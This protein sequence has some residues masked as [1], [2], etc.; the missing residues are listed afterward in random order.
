MFDARDLVVGYGAAHPP[1]L[2]GVSIRVPAGSLCAVLGPNGSGK[3]T[4]MRALLGS[5]PLAT[6]SVSVDGIPVGSW[7]RRALARSVGVVTQAESL[8]FPISVRDL[9]AMGRYP[10][11][12]PFEAE[13]AVDREAIQQALTLCD[14]L[15]LTDRDASSLSGG[16]IQ[17]VRIARAL[18][19]RPRALVLDEPT[20]S[21]DI[22][23]E[24]GILGLLRD[25]ADAG[26]AV[27]LVTH[28]LELASQFADRLLLLN[29]GSVAA[30]GSATDV[31]NESTLREVYDWPIAVRKDPITQRIS[32]TPA[33]ARKPNVVWP[34]G[35]W[36]A[37][38][39]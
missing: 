34:E 22:R 12:G 25:S 5:L 28:Q 16:E 6:G 23:H 2:T 19:Q 11:L 32:I 3:S 4:L 21:L 10:H 30:E 33:S 35:S 31:L 1:A 14:A 27:I 26:L 37:G 9:V 17:R 39:E 20:A 24:M 18:A 13:R 15:H 36:T 7:S 29:E 38:N 8:T